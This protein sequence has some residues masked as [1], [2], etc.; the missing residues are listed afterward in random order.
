MSDPA[1]SLSQQ[2]R[3]RA[4]K[5]EPS[6][7]TLMLPRGREMKTLI[8]SVRISTDFFEALKATHKGDLNRQAAHPSDGQDCPS[9]LLQYLLAEVQSV[10][11]RE[12]E[13][14]FEARF[15]EP[16]GRKRGRVGAKEK[17]VLALRISADLDRDLRAAAVQMNGTRSD[18]LRVVWEEMIAT[19]KRVWA[20]EDEQRERE[21]SNR[22]EVYRIRRP[23]NISP[24]M[25]ICQALERQYGCEMFLRQEGD[26]FII[27]GDVANPSDAPKSSENTSAPTEGD[28]A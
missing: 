5:E 10:F 28:H 18:V 25:E 22:I 23:A 19:R 9:D 4:Q 7:F 15:D 26:F 14:R 8:V 13:I 17:K 6:S 20:W 2:R 12:R 11:H 3:I 24:L 16:N 21:Q 1:L 27:E